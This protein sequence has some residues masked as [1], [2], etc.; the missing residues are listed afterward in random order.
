MYQM[1]IFQ[2]TGS[3]VILLCG[4]IMISL[5]ASS[6]AHQLV[7]VSAP[8]HFPVINS[9]VSILLRKTRTQG[10]VHSFMMCFG[11][12]MSV[13]Y[14]VWSLTFSCFLMKVSTCLNLAHLQTQWSDEV[15]RIAP[16]SKTWAPEL[17]STLAG[18]VSQ[19]KSVT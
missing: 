2:G 19:G 5:V 6:L 1:F 11:H 12:K 14:C 18:C 9:R 10:L 7:F 16:W 13:T 17:T 15:E 8:S 4:R 3:S